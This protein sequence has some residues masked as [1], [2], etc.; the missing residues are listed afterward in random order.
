M[1]KNTIYS[2]ACKDVEGFQKMGE[3]EEYLYHLIQKNTD[4]LSS[5]KHL[6]YGL[7]KLYQLFDKDE[8]QLSLPPIERPSKLPVVFSQQEMKKLLIAPK[9]IRVRVMIGLIYDIGLRMNELSNLL[10]SDIDL[11]RKQVHVRQSKNKKD[12]YLT[13]SSHAVRGIKKHLM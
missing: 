13:M 1:S 11:D 3:L 7:R 2:K 5:F 10:I 4:S 6:V 9:N 12:R 8:L